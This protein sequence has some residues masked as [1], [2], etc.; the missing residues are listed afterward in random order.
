MLRRKALFF[1]DKGNDGRVQ[2]AAAGAHHKAVKRR[3]AHG[4]V[5]DLAVT[6][7]GNGRAVADVAG[8]HLDILK[9]L[10]HKMRAVCA[11]IAVRSA[12][13][14]I[15]ANL[16]LF[17]IF[18]GDRIHIGLARHS[19]MEGGVEYNALREVL[20]KHLLASQ[21]PL[22]FRPVVQRSERNQAFNALQYLIIHQQ[23]FA[24]HRT[25]LR[26]TVADCCNL[27]QIFNNAVLF[28]G[29]RLRH[30][31][32]GLCVVLHGCIVLCSAAIR[33]LMA[34]ASDFLPNSFTV[35]LCKH[36]FVVHINQLIFQRGAAG[37]NNQYL[38]V[39]PPVFNK[40][41]LA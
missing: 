17:I 25:A 4:R 22:Q 21:N 23:G 40:S 7:S 27:G 29:Q 5:N 31:L 9:G 13:E 2:R 6:N 3:E 35:S 10:V 30:Q 38:H 36:L 15:A 12:V 34:E 28:V 19:G 20:P 39:D 11:D 18:I 8:N 24:E 16:I 26:H 33:C 14:A 41:R 37:I 1:H 32:E